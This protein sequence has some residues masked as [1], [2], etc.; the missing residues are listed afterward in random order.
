MD[1]HHIQWGWYSFHKRV[2]IETILQYFHQ[3]RLTISL[4][5]SANSQS[6]LVLTISWSLSACL[7]QLYC[8][9]HLVVNEPVASLVCGMHP[10]K[11]KAISGKSPGWCGVRECKPDIQKYAIMCIVLNFTVC[12]SNILKTVHEHNYCSVGHV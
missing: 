12:E 11:M 3:T 1:T 4:P 10:Q 7:I 8:T 2:I 6:S 5:R 9:D